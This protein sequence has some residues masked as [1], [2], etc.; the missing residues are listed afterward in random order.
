[1][2]R[3]ARISGLR[4]FEEPVSTQVSAGRF[5]PALMVRY[6][7]NG[8]SY[9]HHISAGRSD[10]VFAYT[11]GEC[12]FVLS[13]NTLLQ[14]VGVEVFHAGERIADLFFDEVSVRHDLQLTSVDLAPDELMDHLMERYGEVLYAV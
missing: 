4:L 1:M 13:L 5:N 2:S 9:E 7:L 12:V 14:Y 10:Y 8:Q 3:L 6:T 11:D